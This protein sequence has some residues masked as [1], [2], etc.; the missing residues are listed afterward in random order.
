MRGAKGDGDG[1][2]FFGRQAIRDREGCE[3]GHGAQ[4]S[5]RA[6]THDGDNALAQ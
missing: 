5:V 1:G 4:F 3:A 2:S 6:C